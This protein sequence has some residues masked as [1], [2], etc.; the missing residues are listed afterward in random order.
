MQNKR[1]CTFVQMQ[2]TLNYSDSLDGENTSSGGFFRANQFAVQMLHDIEIQAIKRLCCEFTVTVAPFIRLI[3][4][5]SKV[6]INHATQNQATLAKRDI[7]YAIKWRDALRIP[8]LPL[9]VALCSPV[10][11]QLHL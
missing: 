7:Y 2:F 6:F 4:V 11:R 5:Q 10:S 8:Y 9:L 3:C 1:K